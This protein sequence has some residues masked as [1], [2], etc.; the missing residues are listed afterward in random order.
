MLMAR[1]RQQG[2]GHSQA[3]PARGEQGHL[4]AHSADQNGDSDHEHLEEH[5]ADQN[6]DP[7]QEH[8]EEHNADQSGDP[9]ADSPVDRHRLLKPSYRIKSKAF[10]LI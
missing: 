3:C 5:N 8:L 2:L 10:M 7:E 9:D 4:Q 1:R 6:G